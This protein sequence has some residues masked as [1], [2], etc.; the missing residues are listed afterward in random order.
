MTHCIICWTDPSTIRFGQPGRIDASAG[1]VKR[2][3]ENV[4]TN[5]APQSAD[6]E[7]LV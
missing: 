5:L 3:Q 2:T 4:T 6:L 1:S 7:G